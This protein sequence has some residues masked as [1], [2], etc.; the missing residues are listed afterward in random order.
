MAETE[1]SKQEQLEKANTKAVKKPKEKLESTNLESGD[2]AKPV[3]EVPK[4]KSA[5]KSTNKIFF[6]LGVML[7]SLA[8]GFAGGYL[9]ISNYKLDTSN[10]EVNTQVV[11][12]Q[13]EAIS[14]V[15]TDVSP[16][17][18]SITVKST[19]TS[20]SFFGEQ[21]YES[22]SAGTGIILSD[23]GLIVTNRHVVPASTT[24]L[25]IVLSDGTEYSD[26]DIV[27][28][29]EFNDIAFLQIKD[30]K[31]LKPA[32]LG[33]SSAA[34]VGDAVVAIGNALGRFEN[35]V[36]SGIVSGLGRPIEAG[37]SASDT[38]SLENLMQ[39]DAA[40]NPG[41]SGG[42]LVNINGEVIGINTAVAGN[43]QNIG[44]AIPI[45][46]VKPGITS[47]QKNGELVRPYLGV[48]Y[49]MLDE[50]IAKELELPVTTGA[51]VS[52]DSG[53]RAVVSG[54]PADDAGLKENDIILKVNDTEIN[55]DN[56]L[57]STIGQYQ[58][59]EK[60]TLTINR[61]GQ[62]QKVEVTLEEV[63]KNIN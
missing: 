21:Q 2:S 17:V 24:G 31:D 12:S 11:L 9:A 41:N 15:A 48:R 13:S 62:E 57:I 46:D 6:M 58:V 34:K 22:E 56:S 14:K 51:L 3:G 44:F 36:T 40:I 5:N 18:V 47:V 53:Q 63:P 30:A 50:A 52:A 8:L 29:D 4:A 42:P 35:T 55:E 23:D 7:L 39:T 19:S 20:N 49:I 10:S 61:D 60:V 1:E 45:N 32:K 16:S 28:R 59:G 37:S 26:I 27:G 43:A 54:S 33:D 25:I 38:E